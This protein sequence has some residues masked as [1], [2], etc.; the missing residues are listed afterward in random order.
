MTSEPLALPDILLLKP[1]IFRDE[2][3]HFLETWKAQEYEKLGVGPFVQDNV[4]ISQRGVIRG[5]HLQHPHGQGK[6]ISVLH[7]RAFDVAVDVRHGSPTFGRWVSAELSDQNGWQLYIPPG[8]AHGFQALSDDVAFHYKCTEPYAPQAERAVRWND[9]SIG[10][11]WPL[12]DAIIGEKDLSA[13]LLA[14]IPENV[15][16]TFRE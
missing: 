2:R 5:L 15:L 3:G 11:M 9:P 4:S 14:D 13:P 12:A 10:V 6:L 7:G 16:P 8:F 1:R